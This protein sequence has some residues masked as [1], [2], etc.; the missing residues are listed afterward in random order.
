MT[1]ARLPLAW[2]PAW[3]PRGPAL[4]LA[5]VVIAAVGAPW[6]A[7]YDPAQQFDL[8]Q[9]RNT[10]PSRTHWLGTDPFARDLLSRLLFGART[11]LLVGAVASSVG[12][13]VGVAGGTAAAFLPPLWERLLLGACDVAR[14]IPR[15]LWYL[16]LLLLLGALSPLPLGVVVGLSA[17]P[18][19]I[20]LFHGEAAALRRRPFMEAARAAGTPLGR[21]LRV[22]LLPHL[23]PTVLATGVLLAADAMA[24]E[25]GLS[26][27][28]VG[29]RPPHP[30]WGNMVQDGMAGLA[31]AWWVAALP[32]GALVL[33]VGAL[34]RLADARPAERG[35]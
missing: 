24:L 16:V 5:A 32:G 21:R 23:L 12:M 17:A 31:S 26:F 35:A 25:A 2:L 13:A 33:T 4:L 34:A 11:S 30:S 1:P 22:Q 18:T 6:L 28:G 10:P 29:V 7:P 19:T 3:L 27:V 14:T 20:R 8:M 9:L 15:L